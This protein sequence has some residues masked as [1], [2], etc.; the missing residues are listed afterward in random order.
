[1]TLT[2][3]LIRKECW[4]HT[5][6]MKS[7]WWW[8][9][10]PLQSLYSA[11]LSSASPFSWPLGWAPRPLVQAWDLHAPL[12]TPNVTCLCPSVSSKLVSLP[13][14]IVRLMIYCCSPIFAL[15]RISFHIKR[16][17]DIIPRNSG[18]AFLCF[19]CKHVQSLF[20]M[21]VKFIFLFA[22]LTKRKMVC[23]KESVV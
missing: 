3:D 4:L 10:L 23:P 16:M 18:I 21:Q 1:M 17:L 19:L 11:N 5:E 7:C 9:W 20:R 14:P 6:N 12:A 2:L 8:R 22:G 13:V 15:V